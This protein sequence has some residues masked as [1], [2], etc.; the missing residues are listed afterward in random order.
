MIVENG[1]RRE[2]VMPPANTIYVL[3]QEDL[4]SKASPVF[5]GALLAFIFSISLFYFTEWWKQRTK[6][7]ELT[8]NIKREMSFNINHLEKLKIELDRLAQSVAANDT[9]IFPVYKFDSFKDLFWRR[10]SRPGFSS[11]GFL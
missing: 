1:G 2:S 5:I 10:Q 3:Q 6:L 9:N 8:Y 7:K 4:I 11:L